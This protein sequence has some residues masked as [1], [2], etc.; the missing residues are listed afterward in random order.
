MNS[1]GDWV[2]GT[3]N[4]QYP[5][6]NYFCKYIFQLL[7]WGD[8]LVIKVP[9]KHEDLSSI[10]KTHIKKPGLKAHAWNLSAGKVEEC[11]PLGLAILA[12]C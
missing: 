8:S 7:S 6:C 9:Y 1:K 10:P 4:S 12:Y 2:Q 5:F 3:G 11:D